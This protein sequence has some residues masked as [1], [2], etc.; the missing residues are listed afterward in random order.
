RMTMFAE[1][2]SQQRQDILV[3]VDQ[4]QM[5]H[6]KHPCSR[7]SIHFQ[8]MSECCV[9]IASRTQATHEPRRPTS[10][11]R[12]AGDGCDCLEPRFAGPMSRLEG[13]DCVSPRPQDV[14]VDF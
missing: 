12:M 7:P 1:E 4:Q 5:S 8:T 13:G 6:R 3:I 10:P 11:S 14:E 9:L 2:G